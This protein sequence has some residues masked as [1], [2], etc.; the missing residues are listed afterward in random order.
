MK[1]A[2]LLPAAGAGARLG[3]GP[4][5]LLEVAGKSLLARAAESFTGE[6]DEV[7]AAVS[8]EAQ[9]EAGRH[10]SPRVRLV[11]GGATRQQSVFALLQ[12]TRAEVV[13]IHDA[14]RP[15]LDRALIREVLTAVKRE[16]AASAAMPMVDTL[17][18]AETGEVR[19]RRQLRAVQTPQGFRRELILEAH[20]RAL[21]EGFTATD[22]A[23]LVR[24]MGCPVALVA[25]SAWLLKVTTPADLELAEALALVWDA[26]R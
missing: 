14:A 12:A 20:R 10:L 24:L 1:V 7:L 25:G 22:D 6:V 26:R 9:A 19:D 13:L 11:A 15:F 17:I 21:N 4:K 16:G 8:L 5:A 3:R 18:E 2:A 23:A